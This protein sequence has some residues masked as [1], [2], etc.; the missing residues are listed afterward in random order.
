MQVS[1]PPERQTRLEP[2]R[3][4]LLRLPAD[5]PFNHTDAGRE[6]KGDGKADS[7]AFTDGKGYAHVSVSSNGVASAVF[8]VGHVLYSTSPEPIDAVVRFDCR[9]SYD[10][11]CADPVKNVPELIEL[12]L[13][14]E[15]AEQR[16]LHELV[17]ISQ[18]DRFGAARREGRDA[19]SFNLRMEPGVSYVL[20]ATGHVRASAEGDAAPVEVRL[21]LHELTV[22]IRAAGEANAAAPLPS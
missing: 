4:L 6:S 21:E 10:M 15:D 17:L 8:Q 14:I 2:G 22:E 19:P 13:L 20:R 16:K 3:S 12:N 9:F 7:R 18:E 1:V 11:R 5:L